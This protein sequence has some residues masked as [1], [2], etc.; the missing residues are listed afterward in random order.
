MFCN[1]NLLFFDNS[2]LFYSDVLLFNL[3]VVWCL[4]K[5]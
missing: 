1:S 5:K 3:L 2:V 4:F